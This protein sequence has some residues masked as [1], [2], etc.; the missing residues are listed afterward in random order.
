MFLYSVLYRMFSRRS[1]TGQSNTIVGS[2]AVVHGIVVMTK[3]GAPVLVSATTTPPT[4]HPRLSK[5]Q[6]KRQ[7]FL[8]VYYGMVTAAGTCERLS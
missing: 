5:I 2:S 3:T 8:I 7:M 6:K 4:T 1:N